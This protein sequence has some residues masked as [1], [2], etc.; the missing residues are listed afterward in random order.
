M[1]EISFGPDFMPPGQTLM[2]VFN[3]HFPVGTSLKSIAQ[4]A[5]N[6]ATGEWPRSHPHVIIPCTN[7][8]VT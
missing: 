4:F 6:Y 1:D 7:L 2:P 3:R 5:Q 8:K